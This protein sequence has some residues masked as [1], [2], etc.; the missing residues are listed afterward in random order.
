MSSLAQE[1]AKAL[2]INATIGGSCT[3]DSGCG[4]ICNKCMQ[5]STIVAKTAV[6]QRLHEG[7]SWAVQSNTG[8][9]YD[10]F[11]NLLS[12]STMSAR[13]GIF[14]TI[15]ITNDYLDYV[16]VPVTSNSDGFIHLY[17][18]FVARDAYFLQTR[19]NGAYN[20]FSTICLTFDS[21]GCSIGPTGPRGLRGLQGEIGQTGWTGPTGNT[22]STGPI[23][24]GPTGHTGPTG[25]TGPTGS[26]GTGP[27]GPTGVI[28]STG[29]TGFTGPTGPSIWERNGTDIS[30]SE[31]NV[32]IGTNTPSYN[33]D[34]NGYVY[35]QY[36]EQTPYVNLPDQ[37]DSGNNQKYLLPISSGIVSVLNNTIYNNSSL[38]VTLPTPGVIGTRLTIVNVSQP[39]VGY[40]FTV[41]TSRGNYVTHC[42]PAYYPSTSYHTFS[43]IP[44]GNDYEWFKIG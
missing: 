16:T 34:V 28:G 35:G 11:G 27:T 42:T 44:D 10:C 13:E 15:L 6:F 31:G 17:D 4:C 39:G 38:L 21:N 22:G 2:E 25:V 5:F 14:S 19:L 9:T 24:T 33:L 43:Y 1:I 40:P 36:I 32:G 41:S 20:K 12:Y 7:S 37:A 8:L 23:G 29:F 3:S 30:Y 26:V 18:V